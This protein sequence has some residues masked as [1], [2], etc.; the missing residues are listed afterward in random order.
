MACREE[1][2]SLEHWIHRRVHQIF[3][4]RSR[5]LTAIEQWPAVRSV[6]GMLIRLHGAKSSHQAM[7]DGGVTSVAVVLSASPELVHHN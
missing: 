3:S 1:Q 5:F 2:L 6:V 4:W 7:P